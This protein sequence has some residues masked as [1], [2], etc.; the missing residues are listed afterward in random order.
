ML[1][2]SLIELLIVV[3]VI[4]I[5]AAIAIPNMLRARISANEASAASSVRTITRAEVTYNSAYPLDG[6]ATSLAALGGSSDNCQPTDTAACLIST[7]LSSGQKS[8]YQFQATAL[9]PAGGIDTAFVIGAVPVT[10]NITGVRD[11]C[12]TNDGVLRA[13]PGK[14]GDPPPSDLSTCT[15]YSPIQ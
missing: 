2:F 14:S 1:G 13:Q 7:D 8:G 9:L 12:S 3:A 6:Y 15:G 11:F 5:L 10:Y 4:L